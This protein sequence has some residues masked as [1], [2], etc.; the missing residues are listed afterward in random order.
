[1]TETLTVKDLGKVHAAIDE[2]VEFLSARTSWRRTEILQYLIGHLVSKH[3]RL[4]S[5]DDAVPAGS[6]PPPRTS[7]PTATLSVGGEVSAL[8]LKPVRHLHS[9]GDRA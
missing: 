5:V 3:D 4:V 7:P 9:V 2:Q 1:M 6:G 8:P